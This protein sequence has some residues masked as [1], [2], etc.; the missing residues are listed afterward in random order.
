MSFNMFFQASDEKSAD[1][2]GSRMKKNGQ[3]DCNSL[4]LECVDEDLSE[5]QVSAFNNAMEQ[6]KE[7]SANI[8]NLLRAG[9]IEVSERGRDYVSIEFKDGYELS[10]CVYL[11]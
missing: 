3:K 9:V 11:P 6:Y 4:F 2:M 5:A 1:T 7:T 10:I 8:D